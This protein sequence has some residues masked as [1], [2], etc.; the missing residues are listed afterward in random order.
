V[1]LPT[2]AKS[3]ALDVRFSTTLAAYRAS[4]ARG[5]QGRAPAPAL[6]KRGARAR[7]R[8]PSRG[9]RCRTFNESKRHGLTRRR[10][11]SRRAR[12]ESIVRGRNGGGRRSP[13]RR[14]SSIHRRGD[15]SWRSTA[16][17][18]AVRGRG[19]RARPRRSS[20]GAAGCRAGSRRGSTRRRRGS[21]RSKLCPAKRERRLRSNHRALA[22]VRRTSW[23]AS[24][25]PSSA[26]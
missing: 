18:R 24:G 21:R 2:A 3:E 17:A 9:A 5:A 19:A 15:G 20:G 14:S 1:E 10:W 12:Q 11:S 22:K 8:R 13:K 23:G 26:P 4:M 25:E 16:P 6:H 7:P